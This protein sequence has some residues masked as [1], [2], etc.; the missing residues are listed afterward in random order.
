MDGNFGSSQRS[1]PCV[2]Y[3]QDMIVSLAKYSRLDMSISITSNSSSDGIKGVRT[4]GRV[5]GREGGRP[6]GRKTPGAWSI[7]VPI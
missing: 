2:L 6:E 5:P 1:Q 3:P 4:A 7:G